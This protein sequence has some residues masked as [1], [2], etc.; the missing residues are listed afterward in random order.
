M[1]DRT[2]RHTDGPRDTHSYIQMV[3][4]IKKSV[5]LHAQQKHCKSN[6]ISITKSL[7]TDQPMNQPTGRTKDTPYHREMRGRF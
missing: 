3:G 5:I 6:F 7:R 1:D 2:D 4:H